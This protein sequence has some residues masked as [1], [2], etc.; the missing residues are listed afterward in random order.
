MSIEALRDMFARP[1]VVPQPPAEIPVHAVGDAPNWLALLGAAGFARPEMWAGLIAEPARR[2]AI[3]AG[4][5]AAAFAA[6][7]AHE[8]AG[9][10]VLARRMTYAD[11]RAVCFPREAAGGGQGQVHRDGSV[12]RAG[13]PVHVVAD[14]GGQQVRH[15]M[16]E[17]H[18]GAVG[19]RV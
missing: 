8:S 12:G 5:R 2:Y 11:G 17:A 18:A 15:A 16:N 14:V 7:V 3:T 1:A 6:T 9:G 10:A 13:Q 4:R 19:Q